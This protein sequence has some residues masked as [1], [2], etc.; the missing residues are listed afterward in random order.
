M[1][2]QSPSC[3]WLFAIP[4]TVASQASVHGVCAARILEWVA[5]SSARESSQSRDQTQASSVSYIGRGIFLPLSQLGSPSEVWAGLKGNR[6]RCH[7]LTP[8]NHCQPNAAGALGR[9]ST[10]RAQ[11]EPELW[12]KVCTVNVSQQTLL[13]EGHML[14]KAEWEWWRGRGRRNAPNPWNFHPLISWQYFFSLMA[15]QV[16]NLLANAGDKGD[17]ALIPELGRSPGGGNGTPVQCSCLKNPM[18]RGAWWTTVWEP[19]R[20]EQNWVT[21]QTRMNQKQGE[22][23]F[24]WRS[25]WDSASW[26][27]ENLPRGGIDVH[28]SVP[29]MGGQPQ[30][31]WH[32]PIVRVLLWLF[33]LIGGELLYNV[34]LVSAIWQ[35][36]SAGCQFSS[37]Q[38]LSHVWLFAT[39]WIAA[40]Q[41]SLSITV[42]IPKSPPCWASRLSLCPNPIPLVF[43]EWWA[44]L[45]GLYSR[46]PRA[47][48]FTHSTSGEE[49]ASQ[50]RRQKR[51]SFDPWVGKILG[52]STWQ[53]APVFLP[54][55]SHGWRS[56][57][58]YSPWGHK[59]S[60]VTKWLSTAQNICVSATVSIH[61]SFSFP[62]CVHN[63]IRY[64]C[65]SIPA[66]Q[67][68]S[69]VPFS[70]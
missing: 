50:C 18:D 68:G 3:V 7:R 60:G 20:V 64:I 8:G 9:N 6:W 13:M 22:S 41:A 54:A 24:R 39:P 33:F 15:Q 44:D 65:T 53:P 1:C 30:W 31:R 45:P 35:S 58:G 69:S 38:S 37:V 29:R 47:T 57:V 10:P 28:A 59:E 11:W 62:F 63:S 25:W 48:Y 12:R 17:V 16:R 61:P 36:E 51:F 67:R 46:L 14:A 43:E 23:K 40:R 2:V 5:I 21:K 19:Q 52:R 49:A 27:G 56:L 55:E 70:P 66:P 4:W 32:A 42:S 26:R 34:G